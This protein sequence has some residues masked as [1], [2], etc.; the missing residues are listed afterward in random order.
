MENMS[1]ISNAKNSL[2]ATVG[3]ATYLK[4]WLPNEFENKLIYEIAGFTKKVS[5]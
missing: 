4:L 5:N 2:P 3:V 1:L